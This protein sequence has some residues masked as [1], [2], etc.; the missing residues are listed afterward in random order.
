MGMDGSFRRCLDLCLNPFY[1]LHPDRLD[2]VTLYP[3]IA[4]ETPIVKAGLSLFT[5]VRSRLVINSLH[6][7]GL[8]PY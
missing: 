5:A 6:T 7:L 3:E 4:P 2:S 1:L 8:Q